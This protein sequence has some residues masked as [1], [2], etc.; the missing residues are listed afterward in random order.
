M[1]VLHGD[2]GGAAELWLLLHWSVPVPDDQVSGRLTPDWLRV[3]SG[4]LINLLNQ[5]DQAAHQHGS[6]H[7]PRARV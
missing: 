6:C 5:V 3:R 1:E 7:R 2:A 4:M